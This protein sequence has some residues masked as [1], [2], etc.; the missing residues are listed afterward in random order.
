[1]TLID[2]YLQAVRLYLPRGADKHDILAELAEH[3]QSKFEEREN[4]LGRALTEEEQT[5]L[6]EAHGDPAFVAT[7]YG[8]SWPGFALG[9][10]M[11]ISPRTFPVY[12][13]AFLLAIAVNLV[14]GTLQIFLTNATLLSLARQLAGT[15]VVLFVVFT[16]VFA[17]ID[18]FLRHARSEAWLFW[19]P[20]LKQ[21]PRWY[22]ATGLVFLG[23]VALAWGAWWNVWPQAPEL[24]FGAAAGALRLTPRWQ[25]LHQVLL[26]LLLAGVAQRA[27]SLARP[28]LTWFPWTVRVLIHLVCIALLY[29]LLHAS[30]IVVA[31]AAAG[32]AAA[33][34]L[35]T[36]I[37]AAVHGW[38]G[39]FAFYWVFNTVWLAWVLAGHV[40]HSM[41]KQEHR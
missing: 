38:I 12:V 25:I 22:S 8:K 32:S 39:G 31:E 10:F 23:V 40:R 28:D 33:A 6:L 18:F 14:V 7:R 21:V 27:I 16:T 5:A 17:G 36:R 9:P 37:D 34:D 26:G 11:L 30:P 19:S 1:M 2:H 41:R 24:L 3:L 4:E 29:P 13:G 15:I 35:A 20:Y